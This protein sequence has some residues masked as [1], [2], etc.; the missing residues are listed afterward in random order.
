VLGGEGAGSALFVA[1]RLSIGGRA[2][3]VQP[4]NTPG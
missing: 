4:L 2:S 3:P 1:T